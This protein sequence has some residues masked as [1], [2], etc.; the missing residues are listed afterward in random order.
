MPGSGIDEALQ[1]VVEG[2][3]SKK[4]KR[5]E[6]EDTL[7]PL[8]EEARRKYELK[9]KIE[10]TEAVVRAL[11]EEYSR[12]Y[13]RDYQRRETIDWKD[14][15]ARVERLNESI[16]QSG[17]TKTAIAAYAQISRGYLSAVLGPKREAPLG[18]KLEFRIGEAVRDLVEKRR[19]DAHIALTRKPR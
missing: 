11:K 12:L 6:E 10:E 7:L 18:R 9:K 2:L 13:A 8:H 17:L 5:R 14:N 19:I 1:A 3:R 16:R 4:D 15:D